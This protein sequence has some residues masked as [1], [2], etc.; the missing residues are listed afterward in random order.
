MTD[1]SFAPSAVSDPSCHILPGKAPSNQVGIAQA[2]E[3]EGLGPAGEFPE[4]LFADLPKKITP[5]HLAAAG[6]KTLALAGKYSDGAILPPFLTRRGVA[7]S[8]AIRREAAESEG[9]SIGSAADGDE[10]LLHGAPAD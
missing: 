9:P 4:L 2:I 6:P 7:R 1:H 10:I 3:A 8:I 5:A